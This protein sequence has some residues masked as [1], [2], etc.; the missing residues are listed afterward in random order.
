MRL[1]DTEG[2]P[3]LADRA[4]INCAH[5]GPLPAVAA[6][7][8]REAIAW[9]ERPW[10]L[11]TERFGD[12]PR[13]LREALGRLLATDPA[14]VILANSASYGLHLLANGLPL[15]AGDAV[16][17]MDGDFPSNL[18][19][20][21]GLE[22]RGVDV[23]TVA[24]AAD[25][26]TVDEVA[27]AL[28]PRTRVVC[29]SW[30]HSFSGR[31]AALDDIGTLCRDRGV[32]LVVNGSQAVGAR[33]LDLS[34]VP[35]DALVGVG[36]KW[37]CGPYGTGYCWIRPELRERMIYNQR[38]WLSMQTAE[39][40]EGGRGSLEPPADWGARRYDIFGTAN[41]FNY[42]AWTRSI[43][44]I[45]EH[46]VEAIAS[47]DAG[48]VDRICDRIDRARYEL[49][50]PDPPAERSTLVF[51]SHRDPSR[52]R[53]LFERLAGE[54]VHVSMRSGKLRVAPHFYNSPEQID[55]LCEVL[56]AAG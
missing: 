29:L 24:P 26:L 7:A 19:P 54:K 46:G 21:Q 55:R 52:N 35:V 45:L 36:F 39:A 4:W 11:T 32:R 41:F 30:V 51:L 37:L 13:R 56:A 43:E 15:D 23:R 1:P 49:F 18:L 20:W 27:A 12:V 48:L 16:L 44:R 25:L 40:L 31:V 9:K 10:E 8:A 34:R 47:H 14:D 3:Q 17:V 6:D 38:Y 22:G 33:P 42:A 28:N 50:V 2:F 5:Q 53:A